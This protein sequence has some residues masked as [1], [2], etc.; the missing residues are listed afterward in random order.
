MIQILGLRTYT[1]SKG[2]LKT[3]E[4][5]FSEGWRATSI[6][7]LFLN[8][9]NVVAKIPLEER[10]NMY[11][12]EASCFEESGRK[13]QSQDCIPFDID[14]IDLEQTEQVIHAF[15][16]AIKVEYLKTAV[17]MSGNGLQFHVML[18]TPIDSDEYFDK[19][20]EFYRVCCD[21]IDL[22]LRK[23]GLKGKADP[24]V[25]SPARLMRLPGTLNKKPNKQERMAKLIQPNMEP[26]EFSIQKISGIPEIAVRDQI[27]AKMLSNLLVPDTKT[28]L[29]ECEFI[30]HCGLNQNEILE[31]EW[32]AMVSVTSRLDNGVE[33]TH[34]MS[35][36]HKGY[37]QTET[38]AKIKQAMAASGPRTCANINGLWG[39]CS[40]CKH[41]QTK[42]KSPIMIVGPT[43]IATAKTGFHTV[44]QDS[45]GN[46]VP[47]KPCHEDLRRYYEQQAPYIMV[48][49]LD[50]V[51]RWNGKHWDLATVNSLHAFANNNFKPKTLSKDWVEFEKV[52]KVFNLRPLEW[53]QKTIEGKL[54]FQNGIL[55]I[56]TREFSPHSPD[57]G[58]RSVLPYSYDPNAT[59]PKFE[60]YLE[61]VM[62]GNSDKIRV[63]KE[64]GGYA[65]SNDSAWAHKALL[66][67]GSGSN[68]KSVFIDVVRGL[69]GDNNH[70]SVTVDDMKKPEYAFN[71]EGKLFN[72]S[73]ET[74][75]YSFMNNIAFK[76][77][78]SGG[79]LSIKPLYK[80]PLQMKNTAKFI[81]AANEMPKSD[82]TTEG[83]LRRLLVVRFDKKYTIDN[84]IP[85]YDKVL[86]DEAPGIL[87]I[88]LEG[89]KELKSRGRFLIPEESNKELQVFKSQNS[90]IWAWYKETIKETPYSDIRDINSENSIPISQLY[91]SYKDHCL[92]NGISKFGTL[93]SFGMKIKE[94]MTN[95]D[96]RKIKKENG[97]Y[98]VGLKIRDEKEVGF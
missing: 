81:F 59:A 19:N 8:I 30:K 43:H 70:S 88:F 78:V 93:I 51:Y 3:K 62:E 24:S 97:M 2:V 57:Y 60:A 36:E 26:V 54:N 32:Y 87:N 92:T 48:E 22:E 84:Q 96:L 42:L 73:E 56:R 34:K 89:F 28:I 16:K 64:F 47:G 49:E 94:C 55:D 37:S 85:D 27:N 38:D 14:H 10:Y 46:I 1:D 83:L 9:E 86:L 53:L 18:K 20:R 45:N 68:G 76:N 91:S 40:E 74:G 39:R 66:L 6:K 41:F 35:C 44:K 98:F 15:C 61:D 7:E 65:I 23:D 11:F 50:D 4:W 79:L 67:L 25:F 75:K 33:L 58:F 77:L 17:V 63:L 52:V 72:A 95:Y 82:D 71:M 69:V 5:G 80:Q 29:E 21:L 90:P 12:T 13:L 31:P